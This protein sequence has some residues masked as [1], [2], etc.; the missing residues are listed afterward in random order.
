MSLKAGRTLVRVLLLAASAFACVL[1]A[2]AQA[3]FP[4]ANGKI[5]FFD[6]SSGQSRWINPDGTGEAACC[7]GHGGVWSPDGERLAYS[8]DLENLRTSAADGSD[9]H[10]LYAYGDIIDGISWSPDA[11]KLAFGGS[12][13]SC[14]SEPNRP[15]LWIANADGS[16]ATCVVCGATHDTFPAW[17]PNGSKIAFESFRDGNV[18][19][20]LMNPDG[21]DQTRL[22]NSAGTDENPNWSPDGSR[23]VFDSMRDGNFEIY[24]MNADGT[25]ATR[26]TQSSAADQRPHWSP[27]G[28]KIAF[29]RG[30]CSF[31]TPTC[32]IYVMNADGTVQTPLR[33]TASGPQWQP[34]PENYIRPK[35]A[36]PT[37]VS[38]APAYNQ[39]P[40]TAENSTHGP[41]L[42]FPSCSPPSRASSHLTVG[43]PDANGQPAKASGLVRYGVHVGNPAT[44]EDEADVRIV[45]SITDVRNSVALV[46]YAGELELDQGLRIT[47]RDNTPSSGE[48]GPGTVV[49]ISYPAAIPCV[50]TADTTVGSTC[51]IDT[52]I[53]AIVPNTVKEGRSSVWELGQVKV[54]DG[55]SD[56]AAGTLG[57]NTLF[58]DEGLFIP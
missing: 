47:D 6:F 57:D 37:R 23:I 43:T 15:D 9:D 46:D 4:G 10:T 17:S 40:P 38:L 31:A 32:E 51:A 7:G 34:L 14:G 3:A 36:A 49:D 16:G 5:S 53:D 56:G 24:S 8:D 52:T 44:A 45:A 48:T 25:G 35:A 39:C 2:A 55:G 29:Q 42:A 33:S 1:P 58:M 30:P 19:I 13:T 50:P 27:D 22:T 26:L 11:T 41:P 18:E 12:C 28:S 21:S 20:Y 54:Y